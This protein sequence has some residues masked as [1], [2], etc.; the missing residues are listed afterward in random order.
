MVD[1]IIIVTMI[2]SGCMIYGVNNFY[3]SD[4]TK[5]F[6]LKIIISIFFNKSCAMG[7]IFKKR[8]FLHFF[9]EKKNIWRDILKNVA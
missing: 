5:N 1:D 4:T 7:F 9:F 2:L 8:N 3:M 6:L